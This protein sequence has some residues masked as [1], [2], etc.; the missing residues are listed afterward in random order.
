MLARV[1]HV[2]DDEHELGARVEDVLAGEEVGGGEEVL[3]K[4]GN[5]MFLKSILKIRNLESNVL[6]ILNI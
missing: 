4:V 5:Y 6:C 3:L 2:R 1:A